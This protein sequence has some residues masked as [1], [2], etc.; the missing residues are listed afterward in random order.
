MSSL[1]IYVQIST[2]HPVISHTLG[3]STTFACPAITCHTQ[4]DDICAIYAAIASSSDIPMEECGRTIWMWRQKMSG[5]LEDTT[6]QKK[7]VVLVWKYTRSFAI[8]A[9]L[10][11]QGFS[12]NTRYLD[13]TPA[14][15]YLPG[16]W[17]SRL[18]L[19]LLFWTRILPSRRTCLHRRAH[20]VSGRTASRVVRVPFYR[21]KPVP[22][23]ERFSYPLT[24]QRTQR[25]FV[26]FVSMIRMKCLS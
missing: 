3:P 2:L 19:T 10:V 9:H 11:S 22:K 17:P 13:F 25:A 4:E 1:Y 5:P 24:P 12:Y 16:Y 18:S 26:Y 23:Q 15:N 6:S 21:L 7:K 8:S 14:M 20:K